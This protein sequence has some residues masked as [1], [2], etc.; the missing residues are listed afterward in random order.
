[1]AD[2]PPRRGSGHDRTTPIA[3]LRVVI[4]GGGIAALETVLALHDLAGARCA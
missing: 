3:P 1:M 2:P 4:V